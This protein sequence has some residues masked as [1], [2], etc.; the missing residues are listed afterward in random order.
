MTYWDTSALLKLYVTEPG[1]EQLF[2]LA[3]ETREPVG[4]SAIVTAEML[5]ALH[6]K[7]A[8][9]DLGAGSAKVIY[10]KF[11]EDIRGN[12]LLVLPFDAEVSA[13]VEKVAGLAYEHRPRIL[14]RSL[15]AIHLATALSAR[16]S[17]LVAI[18]ERLRRIA[19]V[20]GLRVLPERL[21]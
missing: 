16:T 18:D 14:L 7:E 11:L 15:D 9:G 19:A 5:C 13:A 10:S 12:R 1:S 20:A 8:D 17:M 2:Q 4:S 6:R 21:S 3:G